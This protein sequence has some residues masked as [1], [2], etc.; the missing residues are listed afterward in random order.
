MYSW[1]CVGII[2]CHKKIANW[3][4]LGISLATFV[5]HFTGKKE[6]VAQA[7]RLVL[8]ALQTQAEVKLRIPREHHK[9]ILGKGGQKLKNLE[10][11]TTAKINISKDSDAITITGTKEGI[12]SA[13]HE[14]QVIS[15]EQVMLLKISLIFE[16]IYT[17]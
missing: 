9:Y 1:Q 14:I 11:Q 13:A 17:P 6:G 8:N 5:L 16:A 15:D 10:L 12:A 2:P 4:F 7:K 3:E